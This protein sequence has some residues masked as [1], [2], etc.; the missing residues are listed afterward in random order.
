MKAFY[1]SLQKQSNLTPQK[2][3]EAVAEIEIRL[4][5]F[6]NLSLDEQNELVRIVFEREYGSKH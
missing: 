4:S 2:F 1:D 5:R 3:D 6:E